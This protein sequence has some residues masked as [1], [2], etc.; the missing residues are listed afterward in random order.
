M[1]AKGTGL[2]TVTCTCRECAETF[3]CAAAAARR[4][5]GQF[6]SRACGARH[7]QAKRWEQEKKTV[8][9]RYETKVIRRGVNECWGWSGFKHRGYGRLNDG[10]GTAVGAHRVSY[11]KHIGPIPDGL[12][13]LHRCD[14]PEC[15]NP[16]HLFLGTNEDNNRDRDQKG[17]TASVLDADKVRE[18]RR[19]PRSEFPQLAERFGVGRAAINA[20]AAR[21]SWRHVE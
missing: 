4:G 1:P 7:A 15:T 20:A 17:R 14:N 6:C 11:E 21:R 2:G 12:T 13:V 18:I 19:S 9:D 16:K 10:T 3:E 5:R 8:A